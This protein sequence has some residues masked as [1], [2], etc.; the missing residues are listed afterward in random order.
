M[1]QF[2]EIFAYGDA[3]GCHDG[4]FCPDPSS[5]F[6]TDERVLYTPP[7]HCA[8]HLVAGAVLSVNNCR[9]LDV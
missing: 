6:E 5:T 4:D 1:C 9:R 8:P 7:M 3:P 2:K